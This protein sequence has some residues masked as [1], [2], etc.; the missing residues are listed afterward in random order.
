MLTTLGNEVLVIPDKAGGL[1]LLDHQCLLKDGYLLLHLIDLG[2]VAGQILVSLLFHRSAIV[3]KSFP[4]V[5]ML[6]LH[7]YSISAANVGFCSPT[8]GT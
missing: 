5:R 3:F 7:L 8:W 2:F 4:C 6:L 1:F